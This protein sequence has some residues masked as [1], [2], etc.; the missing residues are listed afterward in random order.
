[1]NPSDRV[2][3]QF[4]DR[5]WHCRP[6]MGNAPEYKIPIHLCFIDLIKVYDSV[7]SVVAILRSYGGTQLLV[8]IIQDLYTGIWCHVRT[9]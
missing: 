1:M 9:F 8:E 3:M 2:T 4:P 7:D 5:S 6:D